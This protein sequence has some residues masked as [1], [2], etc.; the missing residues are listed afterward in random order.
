MARGVM[1]MFKLQINYTIVKVTSDQAG[2]YILLDVTVDEQKL[3]IVNVY[4]PNHD[5]PQFFYE[6]ID[7][8]SKHKTQ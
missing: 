7:K 2:R 1:I 3:L 6:I 5:S 8:I 4:A